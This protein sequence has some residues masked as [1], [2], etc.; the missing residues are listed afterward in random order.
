MRKDWMI[1]QSEADCLIIKILQRKIDENLLVTGCAGSGKSVLAL[2]KALRVQNERRGEYSVIV[3]TKALCAFMQSGCNFLKLAKPV[4]Y[5]DD[6]LYNKHIP[7]AD[8]VIDDEIQ[9]FTK[10]EVQAFMNNARKHF[11]FFG[12]EAQSVYNGFPNGDG[13]KKQTVTMNDIRQMAEQKG[14][15]AYFELPRNYRLP[16]P[17][18]RITQDYIGVNVPKFGDGLTYMSEETA[19]P[20][21]LCY[22]SFPEQLEAIIR[23]IKNRELDDVAI[24]FKDNGLIPHVKDCLVAEDEKDVSMYHR[25]KLYFDAKYKGDSHFSPLTDLHFDRPENPKL[26]TFHSAKGLQFEN[27]FIPFLSDPTDEMWRKALYVAMT[28]TYRNLFLMYSG[29]EPSILKEIPADLYEVSEID[30][31]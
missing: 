8:Y 18:A 13:T 22:R 6:W 26:L 29:D 23:I 20:K 1:N 4:L 19:K 27:V 28:R 24:L 3:Y 5:K 30:K 16:K 17:V 2:Y 31:I 10:D 9:D 15:C 21:I 7:T 11:F 25:R 14:G 12:D